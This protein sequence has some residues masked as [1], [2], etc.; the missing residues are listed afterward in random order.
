MHLQLP[1]SAMER[2]G[3]L[4]KQRINLLTGQELEEPYDVHIEDR[5]EL[6]YE[7]ISP[8]DL[9]ESMAKL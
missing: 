8:Q 6:W 1:Q 5:D 9:D 3:D 4:K 7:R 2:I